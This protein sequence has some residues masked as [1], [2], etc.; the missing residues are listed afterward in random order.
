MYELSRWA[1]QDDDRWYW[2][3]RKLEVWDTVY[4]FFGYALFD[5]FVGYCY[6]EFEAREWERDGYIVDVP[7]RSYW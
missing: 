5:E 1:D 4:D 3:E 2:Y 7:Q 6:G